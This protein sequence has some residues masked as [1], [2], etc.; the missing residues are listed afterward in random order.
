MAYSNGLSASART[1]SEQSLPRL[2]FNELL[3]AQIE[4]ARWLKSQNFAP[5]TLKER[6]L[7]FI[8]GPWAPANSDL[9][10]RRSLSCSGAGTRPYRTPCKDRSSKVR[11]R[12]R[13]ATIRRS[14][15]RWSLSR[16]TTVYNYDVPIQRLPEALDG[17]SILHLSD[18][19][20]LKGNDLP[21]QELASIADAVERRHESFDIVLLSG[22]IITKGPGDLCANSLRAL[23]RISSACPRSFMV[24]GNHDYHG[25]VPALISTQLGNVGF[26]DINNFHVRLRFGN[27]PLNIYGVDDAYFGAPLA[28]RATPQDEI[29]IILTHNLDSIRGDC[30]PNID[31]ILSGHTHWGEFR[32]F[33]G[34]KLMTLWG[35]CDNVNNHTRHWDVLTDRTLSFV[36]P[37]LARYYVPFRT[38]RHPPGIAIHTLKRSL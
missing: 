21:W 13:A 3:R 5:P 12:Q 30:C 6:L 2:D 15:H 38:L 31:L 33:D 11:R 22:D 26:H 29:N 17:L 32:L 35:Y 20:L 34:S 10:E 4:H 16:W 7:S 9:P 8:E 24:H 19:H 1:P 18:I 27:T 14:E 36:H 28:P 37:G 25:H 23:E